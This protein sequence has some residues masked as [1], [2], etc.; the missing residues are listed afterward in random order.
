MRSGRD[1][2]SMVGGAR[3]TRGAWLGRSLKLGAA[4]ACSAGLLLPAISGSAAAAQVRHAHWW[5]DMGT[6]TVGSAVQGLGFY[7]NV[8]TIDAGDAITFVGQATDPDT[9]SFLN[10]TRPPLPGSPA[11]LAPAGGST[12][13]TLGKFVSSGLL[14]P[15]QT[16]VVSF[17]RPGVFL[18]TSLL[19]GGRQGV[20]IVHPAG[21]PYPMDQAQYDIQAQAQARAD[22]LAGLAAQ[23]S[24]HMFTTP[25]AGSTTTYHVA[26]GISPPEAVGLALAPA[27]GSGEG[28][29]SSG[30]VMLGLAG[31]DKL[32][33]SGSLSGLS[34]GS[35]AVLI[36]L[37][38]CSARAGIFTAFPSAQVGPSGAVSGHV[39]ASV[40][41]ATVLPEAGWFVE[42]AAGATVGSPPALCGNVV[43]HNATVVRFL[44]GALTI[45]AGDQVV[46]TNLSVNNAHT[47]T[48][49]APGQ[50]PPP[51]PAVPPA[52]G[53]TLS[54]PGYFNSGELLPFQHYALTF[55]A[56][57]TYSYRC[58]F[59]DDIGMLASVTVLSRS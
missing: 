35:H 30:K 20:V 44:P 18:E 31:P 42:V 34:R 8:I 58:L 22:L 32:S 2:V 9:V 53:T 49:L 16:F 57:G 28:I 10:G 12:C 27:A 24:Y 36:G 21:T 4:M 48:F 39:L 6:H 5:V 54:S 25:G 15:G 50:S 3:R 43:F 51:N 41:P 47:V 29:H 38:T 33:L 14:L 52:G 17:W 7:P 55:S 45:H 13:C 19:H 40:P 26:A 37:G 46:W 23:A 1:T 59:H 56:P 11:S